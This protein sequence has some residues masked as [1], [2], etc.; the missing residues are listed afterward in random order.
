MNRLI[1]E[2]KVIGACLLMGALL[3]STFFVGG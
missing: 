2:L 1:L 3:G